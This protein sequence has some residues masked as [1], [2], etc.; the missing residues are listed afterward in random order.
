[1]RRFVAGVAARVVPVGADVKTEIRQP[2]RI[3]NQEGVGMPVERAPTDLL[4]RL[5]CGRPAAFQ[6]TFPLRKKKRRHVC[7]FGGKHHPAHRP[8]LLGLLDHHSRRAIQGSA[9]N[10]VNVCAFGQ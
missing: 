4:E 10:A 9:F 2:V 3:E 5:D 8:P 1:M 7:D 6:R